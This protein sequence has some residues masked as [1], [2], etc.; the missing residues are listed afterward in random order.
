[1]KK[2]ELWLIRDVEELKDPM[3][4]Y[5]IRDLKS[6]KFIFIGKPIG[7][8]RNKIIHFEYYV[9]EVGMDEHF[10]ISIK[11]FEKGKYTV[12]KIVNLKN[13]SKNME[14]SGIKGDIDRDAGGIFNR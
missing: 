9:K 11:E 13:K 6:N 10:N 8:I 14:L 3:A 7:V 12:L 4:F 2:F 1:M 5:Q